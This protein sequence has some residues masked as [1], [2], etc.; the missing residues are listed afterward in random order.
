MNLSVPFEE[1]SYIVR[2]S[3]D[4][5]D[6]GVLLFPYLSAL[7]K[8]DM[9]S[10]MDTLD[11]YLRPLLGENETDSRE[12][13]EWLRTRMGLLSDTVWGDELAHLYSGIGLM[14]ES[15]S[16]LRVITTSNNVYQG[17]CLVGGGY[18]LSQFD[19]VYTPVLN[20]R[21]AEVFSQASPHNS[22]FSK[23]L[24]LISFPEDILREEAKV[25]CNTVSKLGSL[26]RQY[27]IN[28]N[29]EERIKLEA[30]NLCFPT[31]SN[32]PAT[33]HNVARVLRAMSSNE[34]EEFFPLHPSMIMDRDRRKRLLSSFGAVAPSFL[35]PG[36]RSVSLD[37]SFSYNVVIKGKKEAR[38]TT[39]MFCQMV[40]IA[41][42]ASDLD[43]LLQNHNVLTPIGTPLAN[44]AS[45]FS[46]IREFS[47]EG[48]VNVLSALR[49]L[50]GVAIVE[51]TAGGSKRGRDGN[52]E[53][54]S[55]AKKVKKAGF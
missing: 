9:D 16:T 3:S 21:F 50:C 40:P 42:A 19:T 5:T 43:L 36:G 20:T 18:T 48:G 24:E 45:S 41:K 14:F 37:G 55:V 29:M 2:S 31:D 27:G 17:F 13:F 34:S 22:S 51:D 12:T 10:I 1:Y 15:G 28:S 49:S 6:N 39:R 44:R 33:A 35:V 54:G 30:R 52:D 26:I 4:L 7:A 46:L 11:K 53:E 47:G 8:R 32:L 38:T 23:I 25:S